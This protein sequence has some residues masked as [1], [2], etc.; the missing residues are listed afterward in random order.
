MASPEAP[1]APLLFRPGKKRKAYRHRAEDDEPAI[2]EGA[3]STVVAA[4][5]TSNAPEDDSGERS[6]AEVLRLRNSRRHRNGVAFRARPSSNTQGGGMTE[7][8]PDQSMVLHESAEGDSALL[9]GIAQRFAPQTGLV[10][11]LVNKH[12]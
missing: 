10:G 3:P 2:A 5:A 11:E 6:V 1:S 9:G 8:N 7:E 4:Q 12:M